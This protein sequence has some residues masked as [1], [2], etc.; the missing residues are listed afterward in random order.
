MNQ[1]NSLRVI[2]Q[3]VPGAYIVHDQLYVRVTSKV[4]A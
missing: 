3:F 2:M 4:V 1:S